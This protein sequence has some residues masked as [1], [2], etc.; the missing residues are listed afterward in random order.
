MKTFFGKL[1]CAI[2]IHDDVFHRYWR[3]SF[4]PHFTC[5]RK[6]CNYFNG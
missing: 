1:L 5:A 2:G 3:G 6:G 4:R